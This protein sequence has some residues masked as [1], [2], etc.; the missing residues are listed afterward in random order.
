MM[1]NPNSCLTKLVEHVHHFVLYSTYGMPCLE[2]SLCLDVF[3]FSLGPMF[4][5]LVSC[6]CPS[7]D[8]TTNIL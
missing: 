4:H 2:G 1:A 5:F 6:D 7:P 3:W 8:N